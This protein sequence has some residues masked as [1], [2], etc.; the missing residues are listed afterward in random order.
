MG[1]PKF[2]KSFQTSI[3]SS[4]PEKHRLRSILELGQIVHPM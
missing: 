2:P 3:L 4:Y 1:D